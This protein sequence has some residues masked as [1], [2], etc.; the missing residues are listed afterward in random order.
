MPTT[1]TSAD[2]SNVAGAQLVA[3]AYSGSRLGLFARRGHAST[4]CLNRA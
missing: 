2:N 4:M 1:G 3:A